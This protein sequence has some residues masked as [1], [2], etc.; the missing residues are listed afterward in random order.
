MDYKSFSGNKISVTVNAAKEWM[1]TMSF[2]REQVISMTLN[3]NSVHNGS[4][5]LTVWYRTN[6]IN[7][8]SVPMHNIDTH[9]FNESLSW[10]VLMETEAHKELKDKNVIALIHTPTG[11][12]SNIQILFFETG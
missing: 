10:D 1:N 4:S 5:I 9:M 2:C 8:N 6:K 11:I 12:K 3:E 7:P